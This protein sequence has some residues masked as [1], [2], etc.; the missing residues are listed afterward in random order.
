MLE[1]MDS[2]DAYDFTLLAF[3]VSERWHLPV[4]LRITTR[5]CHSKTIV[6]PTRVPSPGSRSGPSPASGATSRRGS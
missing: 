6:R 2:Q 5:V 4:M 1:P 3:E